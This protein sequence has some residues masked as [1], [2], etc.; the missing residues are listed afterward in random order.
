MSADPSEERA[1][2]EA[3]RAFRR[4]LRRTYMAFYAGIGAPNPLQVAAFR[5]LLQGKNALLIAPTATG[6]TEAAVAPICERVMAQRGEGLGIIYLA[7][8]KALCREM[9]ERLSDCLAVLSREVRVRTG[10]NPKPPTPAP[11]MLVTTIE[12]LDS[13][14]A[15]APEI[16]KDTRAVILDE[17]H[18]VHGSSRGSQLRIVLDRLQ[19]LKGE[20]P[21]QRVAL[22]ATIPNPNEVV[23]DYLGEGQILTGEGGRETWLKP[24]A[25]LEELVEAMREEGL[26]RVLCF[27]ET[28]KGVEEY[29]LGLREHFGERRVM[30]HHAGMSALMRHEV[31]E[32]L[33][34]LP[35]W[36]CV[37]TSTLEVGIDV[38]SIEAVALLDVP[39]R[40]G[41][42]QQRIGRGSR[43]QQHIRVYALAPT[44]EDVELYERLVELADQGLTEPA[45]EFTVDP[46]VVVQQAFSTLFAEP[47]GVLFNDLMALLAPLANPDHILRILEHLVDKDHIVRRREKLYPNTALMDRGRRGIVHANLSASIEVQVVDST[48]GK[49]IGSGYVDPTPGATFVLGGRRWSVQSRQGNKVSVQPAAKSEPSGPAKRAGRQSPWISYLPD[50]FKKGFPES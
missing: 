1:R 4:G 6:K 32:A 34:E 39:S 21:L 13:L 41:S 5:P 49:A 19:R 35:T 46:G 44:P 43:R 28:R 3:V 14:L 48:S 45:P 40:S 2:R 47:G 22:S 12:S 8:T 26:R 24:L 31:E 16:L 30:V 11:F 42:F 38:G 33:R 20:A 50:D 17:I 36:I 7:P 10:D 29:A 25:S 37:A 15:R 18:M 27:A 9:S 23:H